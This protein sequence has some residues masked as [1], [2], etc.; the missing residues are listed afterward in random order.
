MQNK[1]EIRKKQVVE[2]QNAI[3]AKHIVDRN[4]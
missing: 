3:Q 4:I 2:L 1:F